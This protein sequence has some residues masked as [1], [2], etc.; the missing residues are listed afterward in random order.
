MFPL[1]KYTWPGPEGQ[2]GAIRKYDIHTG[3]DLY[4]EPGSPVYSIGNGF[5]MAV[6]DFTGPKAGSPWW[7]D[8]QSVL[9]HNSTLHNGTV[10]YGEIE[11]A[12]RP[13]WLVKEGDIIGYVKTVLKKDKGKPMT[14]LHFELYENILAKESVVWPLN[15]EKPEHLADPTDLLNYLKGLMMKDMLQQPIRVGDLVVNC[16]TQYKRAALR[17]GVVKEVNG[18]EIKIFRSTGSSGATNANR[19]VVLRWDQIKEDH[20]DYKKLIAVRDSLI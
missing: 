18:S 2:F 20:P 15:T 6:E 12:V 14:M 16:V 19:L 10:C 5:V 8:T 9:V 13:G 7:N 3:V 4:C 1:K 11:S 17:L